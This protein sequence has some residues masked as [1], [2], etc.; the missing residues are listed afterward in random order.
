MSKLLMLYLG[1]VFSIVN[2]TFA[3]TL[4]KGQVF[5]YEVG[6]HWIIRTDY[7][8]PSLYRHYYVTSK[9]IYNS[10]SIAYQFKSK[11]YYWSF[12]DWSY[13]SFDSIYSIQYGSLSLPFFEQ[14]KLKDTI[15]NVEINGKQYQSY[16][17]KDS[18]YYDSCFLLINKRTVKETPP[19]SEH[20]IKQVN[21]LAGIGVLEYHYYPLFQDRF[22]NEELIYYKKGNDSCGD[23]KSLPTSLNAVIQSKIKLFPNPCSDYFKVL[24]EFSNVSIYNEKGQLLSTHTSKNEPISVKDLKNGIYFIQV[25]K[26]NFIYHSKLIVL[27]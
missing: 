6:D 11:N 3:Q 8:G 21:A 7:A 26:N 1:L 27:H 22:N 18:S 23:I 13:K 5:D 15:I 20:F 24:D 25:N 16:S 10:D 17:L 9:T 2:N 12:T 4:S 19:L 14:F